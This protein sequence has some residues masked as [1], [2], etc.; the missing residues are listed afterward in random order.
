MKDLIP[1]ENL[2]RYRPSGS[3]Y[4]PEE[5]RQL[6]R[7]GVF[8][9]PAEFLNDPFDCNPAIEDVPI[10]ELA[11]EIRKFG[12]ERFRRI[13][14]RR[15]KSLGSYKKHELTLLREKYKSSVSSAEFEAPFLSSVYEVH[16]NNAL[17]VSCFSEVG[18]STLMWSHYA[19]SHKGFVVKYHFDASKLHSSNSALPLK[20]KYTSQRPKFTT[21]EVFQH[22]N[23]DD[24]PADEGEFLGDP[25]GEGFYLTKSDSWK[26][27]REWRLIESELDGSKLDN[28]G[29]FFYE[30][31]VP[32]KVIAGVNMPEEKVDFVREHLPDIEICRAKVHPISFDLC[33][34]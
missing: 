13:R 20:V 2:Y 5:I 7:N 1:P 12:V 10:A 14:L 28:S 11:R 31:L 16:R 33:I 30:N 27:E 25:V 6:R 17:R 23:M 15:A 18:D 34:E 21:I 3:E 4:F 9:T 26:E 24:A 8:L 29:Y 22:D 19:E 32:I